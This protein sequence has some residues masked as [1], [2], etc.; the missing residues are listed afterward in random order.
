MKKK[1]MLALFAAATLALTACGGKDAKKEEAATEAP[2][3]TEAGA[4]TEAPEKLEGTEIELHRAYSAPHGEKSFANVVVAMAG[5]KILAA[6]IDE[7]QF[8]E[9]ANFKGVPNSDADFATGYAEG[10]VLFSKVENDEAYSKMMKEYAQST[11]S[12]DDNYEAIQDF[13]K[14]KTVAEVEAVI[15]G[16]EDGKAID[17]VT[18]ATM[19]DTKGYLQSIV[20]AAK[21]QTMVS[22]GLVAGDVNDIELEREYKAPH[23]TRG[24]ADIVVAEVGDKIVAVNMD[25]FQFM[26]GTGVPNSDKAFAQGYADAATPLISKKVNNEAYSAL[27]KD[28]AKATKTILESYTAIE[29]FAVGK[30]AEEVMAAAGKDDVLDAVSGSTLADTAAYLRAIAETAE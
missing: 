2:A 14:G 6:E 22:K 4:T 15:N 27:M 10:Q 5:D 26:A 30:T 8:G 23:G 25:E 11:V 12:L 29:D 13:V 18:G 3:Q 19:V 16:A 17:A 1:Q 24:F 21:D 28:K 20:D 9:A 7:F